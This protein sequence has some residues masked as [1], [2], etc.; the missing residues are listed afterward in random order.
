MKTC[1]SMK[2]PEGGGKIFGDVSEEEIVNPS[3]NISKK[4]EGPRPMSITP[5][6]Y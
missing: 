6:A 5:G 4:Q 1:G 3:N 2:G